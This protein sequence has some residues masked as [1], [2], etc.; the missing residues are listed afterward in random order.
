MG[1]SDEMVS[2]SAAVAL[3]PSVPPSAS[4]SEAMVQNGRKLK[5]F[6][7]S[8]L[9]PPDTKASA[10]IVFHHGAVLLCVVVR[11]MA[12]WQACMHAR[13]QAPAALLA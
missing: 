1:F 12:R 2:A 4:Y 5:L 3:P 10:I 13:A 11:E 9:P 8:W 6:R 7:A